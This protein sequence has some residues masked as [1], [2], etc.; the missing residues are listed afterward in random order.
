MHL[1][2]RRIFAI[3]RHLKLALLKSGRTLVEDWG[4]FTIDNQSEYWNEQ[5]EH[6]PISAEHEQI[7]ASSMTSSE[8][9]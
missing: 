1:P 5:R 4:G 6:W 7:L 8:T 3:A 9:E 2:S